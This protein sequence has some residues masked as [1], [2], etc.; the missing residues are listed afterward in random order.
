MLAAD[1]GDIDEDAASI[2]ATPGIIECTDSTECGLHEECVME[3]DD[4]LCE[5]VVGY[6]G[7]PCV[8]VGTL[9]SPGFDDAS[10]WQAVKGAAVNAGAPGITDPGEGQF[11]SAAMC[12]LG[13]LFQDIE[14]P[15]YEDA[16]P[17]VAEIKY[18]VNGDNM[19]GMQPPSVGFND[20]WINFPQSSGSDLVETRRFCLS[21]AAYG[22]SVR[23]AIS[24][25]DKPNLG[26]PDAAP[27][28]I[29]VDYLRIQPANPGECGE[30]GVVSNGDMENEDNWTLS[31]ATNN[32]VSYIDG[33]GLDGSRALR[34]RQ[35]TR[36]GAATATGSFLVPG[37]ERVANPALEFDYQVN[38]NTP[39]SLSLDGES[40]IGL[41]ATPGQTKRMCLPRST[42]GLNSNI[43]IR[44]SG[45]SGLCSDVVNNEIIIDN[46]RVVD[47]PSCS[48]GA[49]V[50]GGFEYAPL[51]PGFQFATQLNDGGQTRVEAI[52]N[53]SLARTGS[54]V[55][56]LST[57]VRCSSARLTRQLIPLSGD[58]T[59]GPAVRVF[60]NV[61]GNP[62]S[63]TLIRLSGETLTLPENG[64][65]TE[66]VLCIPPEY[67]ERPTPMTLTI[68][69]GSGSCSSFGG[70]EHAFF[71]DI[72][73][74]RA[75]QCP[76]E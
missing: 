37:A 3:G 39:V 20:Q 72:E 18:A 32:D 74:I 68:N 30:P 12:G 70:I 13:V 19:F 60:A 24:P 75:P 41:P 62:V 35:V 27:D 26:C 65:W 15:R 44:A 2:D 42:H 73:L 23:V 52:S 4:A 6:E 48:V 67:A 63:T 45:G 47:E 50:D 21:D 38:A 49:L 28:T 46:L 34:V 9:L 11:S 58:A 17:L 64:L 8:F 40:F 69:G 1:G 14:M 57:E 29:R 36:C 53:P 71:D 7:E 16:E 54:G 25:R 10:A 51:E 76:S 55:L 66:H 31:T 59:G 5:C 33:I 22:G 61:P 43:S 56:D